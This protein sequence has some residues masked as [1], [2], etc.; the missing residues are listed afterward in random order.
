MGNFSSGL[1]AGSALHSQKR[2]LSQLNID[3]VILARQL[4]VCER[5][6]VYA[7]AAAHPVLLPWHQRR[8]RPPPPPRRREGSL[9]NCD[10]TR[11]IYS[12]TL[13]PLFARP[14]VTRNQYGILLISMPA[15]L[16]CARAHTYRYTYIWERSFYVASVDFCIFSI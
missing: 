6:C 2:E 7:S 10:R 8:L 13:P 14:R 15:S 16:P 1:A 12:A 3:P 9:S 4:C 11:G 5:A